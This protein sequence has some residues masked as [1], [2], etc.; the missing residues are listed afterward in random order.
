MT[1]TMKDRL[2]DMAAI[3]EA[4]GFDARVISD[5]LD[6]DCEPS[7]WLSTAIPE[8]IDRVRY[9]SLV[10]SIEESDGFTLDK[11]E[12]DGVMDPARIR[13][14]ISVPSRHVEMARANAEKARAIA[15]KAAAAA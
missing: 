5:A 14:V 12:K 3:F 6:E 4:N 10:G 2:T 1:M 7:H 13:I 11:V 15:A 9:W 8:R